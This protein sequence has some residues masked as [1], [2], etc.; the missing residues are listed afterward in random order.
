MT[1]APLHH[2]NLDL[3]GVRDLPAA[4]R[5]RALADLSAAL[6]ASSLVSAERCVA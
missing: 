6:W 4:E 2:V 3:T 5:G 1:T